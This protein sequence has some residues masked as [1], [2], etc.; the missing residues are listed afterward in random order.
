MHITKKTNTY[1]VWGR[2]HRSRKREMLWSEVQRALWDQKMWKNL[3]ADAVVS[4]VDSFDIYLKQLKL[5]LNSLE[6]IT[7][8]I[9]IIS[10]FTSCTQWRT[11]WRLVHTRQCFSSICLHLEP[12]QISVGVLLE[13]SV[14]HQRKVVRCCQVEEKGYILLEFLLV[15]WF[16]FAFSSLCLYP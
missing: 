7:S 11:R 14:N 5:A 1:F 16:A 13:M 6:G 9:S 4:S 8:Y 12:C 15:K 10:S 2:L 3:S